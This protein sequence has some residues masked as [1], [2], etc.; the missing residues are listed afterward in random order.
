M[1]KP[2]ASWSL[3]C[4]GLIAGLHTL[5]LLPAQGWV[6]RTTSTAPSARSSSA[7][8]YDVYRG[9][10]TLFGGQGAATAPLA[11]TWEYNGTTWTPRVTPVRPSARAGHGMAFDQ[12]RG[13]AV[14]FGGQDAGGLRNDTW[15][16]DGTSWQQRTVV[17]APPARSLAAM[18][19]DAARGV[20]V[21][22]GGQGGGQTL[23]ADTWEYDGTAWTLRS[24]AGAPS[25]RSRAACAYDETRR[26]TLLFGGSDGAQALGDLW[27]WNGTAWSQKATSTAPAA[28][29]DASVA[30]DGNC[31]RAVLSGG[32]DAAGATL[33]GD[34]WQWDGVA[35]S[36]PAGALPPARQGAVQVHDAQRGQFVLWGGRDAAGFRNDTWELG[37][38]CSRTMA[39]VTQPVVGQ[40]AQFRYDYPGAAAALHFCFPLVTVRQPLAFAVPIPGFPS[41]GLCRV[42][43]FSAELAPV[44]LDGSGSLTTALAIPNHPTLWGFEFDVQAVDLDLYTLALRWAENDLEVTTGPAPAVAAF[45]A[46]PTSGSAPLTV[47]FANTSTYATS[48]AWTFGDGTSSTLPN[49]PPKV[50]LG[51]T[52]T[53]TLTATGPGGVSTAQQQIVV[54]GG[55]AA[56][57]ASFTATPTSGSA[58]LT[59]QFSDTSTQSPLWWLWDF[60]NDGVFDSAQQNPSWTYTQNGWYSV[61]LVVV[62][63]LGGSSVTRTAL[64]QVGVSVNPA[65]NM[66]PIAPGTFL[67]GSTAGNPDEQPVRQVTLTAPFWMGKYEVTQ[68]EY[69]AVVGSNPSYFQGANYPNAAQRPVEQVSGYIAVAYCQAL[70]ASEQAAGRVPPGYQYRLPTEAEWEYCCRAGTTTEWNTGTSLGTSQA[71]FQGGQT[72]VVG[73]YAPNAFGLH[74]MHGN[75]WEWCLDTYAGYAPGPVSDPFVTGGGYRVIR[76][77]GW[78][79]SS[80]AFYCRSAF[81]GYDTPGIT[82][83]Y[84]GL[85]VVLAPVL[86]TVP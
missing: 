14:L 25:A 13:R 44:L 18:A 59:V 72:A 51:G 61:R 57:V 77:G 31:G 52:Y 68:A 67:M 26:E 5:A 80:T 12:R 2:S 35:W 56:P 43:L 22:F 74:D 17:G 27:A 76:G 84:V 16:W 53:V 58:P 15:E 45:T 9:V 47:S 1:A 49:P 63:F 29:M 70:T 20:C 75:V 10:T 4:F 38:S 83:S 50:Y 3:F 79:I 40:T 28:R 81:R 78:N 11:D 82:V 19:Y 30:F 69:Q 64:V 46:T 36:Q 32:G 73:S 37:P 34:S 23:L 48:Y 39:V 86:V 66:V 60:D 54:S 62:N 8:A 85:R 65:L 71:N 41:I 55:N 7:T 6:Q 24:V 21:L 42:D 33:P